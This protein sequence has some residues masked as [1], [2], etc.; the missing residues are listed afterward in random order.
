ML[1]ALRKEKTVKLSEMTWPEV[2][3]LSKET[4]VVFP[5]ASL[6]Q[7]SHHLP[8]FTDSL[9]VGS[10]VDAVDQRIGDRILVLPVQWLGYSYHHTPFGGTITVA[11]DTHIALLVETVESLVRAGFSRF[12]ILNGHGG[13]ISDVGV[14]LQKLKEQYPEAEVWGASYWNVA[15]SEIEAIRESPI[16]GIGHAGEMETSLMLHLYPQLVR[17]DRMEPDGLPSKSQFGL[18]DMF[19]IGTVSDFPMFDECTRHGGFG[20]PSS[21]SAEKGARFLRAITD[22][23]IKVIED[24]EAN[25]L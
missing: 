24:I 4:V 18:K 2:A 1:I 23:V 8:F 13:N 16:G 19:E 25:I 15:R 5:I 20:D 14:A 7:H 22:Q 3:A 9:L 11:S 10:V 6:E 21:A 12:L 17:R